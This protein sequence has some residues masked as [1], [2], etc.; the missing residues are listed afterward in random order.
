MPKKDYKTYIRPN[1]ARLINTSTEKVWQET[2]TIV[3]EA[4]LLYEI[5]GF[6]QAKNYVRKAKA[7]SLGKKKKI[8]EFILELDKELF[9]ELYRG[10]VR[11]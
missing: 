8:L 1:L 3:V 9:E 6:I 11:A 7:G 5:H 10:I 4:G 2:K